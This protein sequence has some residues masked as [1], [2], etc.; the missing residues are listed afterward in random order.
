MDS[1]IISKNQEISRKS[2]ELICLLKDKVLVDLF[3]VK[4]RNIEEL[5]SFPIKNFCHEKHNKSLIIKQ[6]GFRKASINSNSN[7]KNQKA[8]IE[9]ISNFLT[10]RDNQMCKHLTPE[11]SK[12]S[13]DKCEKN[14]TTSIISNNPNT[15]NFI[16]TNV[17]DKG[18]IKD[19]SA[20]LTTS[21][22]V[23]VRNT[24][25]F[26]KEMENVLIEK[27]KEKI[28][29]IFREIKDKY[30]Q[31]KQSTFIHSSEKIYAQFLEKDQIFYLFSKYFEEK[32]T[33]SQEFYSFI[34]NGDFMEQRMFL[35]KKSKR[36]ESI[37]EKDLEKSFY[38]RKGICQHLSKVINK[39]VL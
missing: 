3:C 29:H 4:N 5:F 36:R 32:T 22:T 26:D 35:G 30:F 10:N 8:I 7:F 27:E 11:K 25:F 14:L 33:N 38:T 21:T 19:F 17:D 31:K 1:F 12:T 15:H 16:E 6:Q 37:S 13:Y 2:S 18:E 28:I 39:L 34:V 9:D 23:D 24:K 20:G